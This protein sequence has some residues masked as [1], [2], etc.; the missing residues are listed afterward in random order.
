MKSS[1][2]LAAITLAACAAGLT[3]ALAPQSKPKDAKPA[4]APAADDPM[5]ANWNAFKTPGAEHK[6]LDAK[7][8]KWT[9]KV[10]CWMKP[11][12]PPMEMTATSEARWILGGRYLQ[13]TVKGDFMGDPFEGLATY[14]FDNMKKKY[15]SSWIDN[16]STAIM[17]SDGTYDAATK[18]FTFTGEAPCML[19]GKYMPVKSTEKMVDANTCVMEMWATD[20]ETGKWFKSME[21]TSTRAK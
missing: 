16:M 4:S 5:M 7:V 3:A 13:G 17:T 2:F 14:A 18:T 11:G 9:D 10:T 12:E 1:R 21:I 19:S 15:V 20:P 6:V 8:G